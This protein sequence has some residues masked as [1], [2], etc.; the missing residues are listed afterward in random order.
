MIV[1]AAANSRNKIT[2]QQLLI[3]TWNAVSQDQHLPTPGSREK[4][5][6]V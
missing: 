2:P 6:T 5:F 4:S 3:M 1:A